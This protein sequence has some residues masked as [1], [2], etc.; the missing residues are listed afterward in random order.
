MK[1]YNSSQG[2]EWPGNGCDPDSAAQKRICDG[3][4]VWAET[5][6]TSLAETDKRSPNKGLRHEQ[7]QPCHLAVNAVLEARHGRHGRRWPSF[8]EGSVQRWTGPTRGL[9]VEQ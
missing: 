1:C 7:G 6:D 2:R 8:V 4:I 5:W 9:P 3:R